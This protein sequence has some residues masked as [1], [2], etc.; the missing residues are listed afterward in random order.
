MPPTFFKLSN[1]ESD[2]ILLDSINVAFAGPCD[3]PGKLMPCAPP[4]IANVC[5]VLA[6]FMFA[7]KSARL[8]GAGGL[9]MSPL[10]GAL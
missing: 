2:F 10:T 8:T 3:P 4:F 7:Y 9:E 6:L 1:S 5:S